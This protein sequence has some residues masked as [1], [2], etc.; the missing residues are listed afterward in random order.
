MN[1][2][3]LAAVAAAVWLAGCAA[4]RPP[5]APLETV[6]AKIAGRQVWS[7][8]IGKVSFPLEVMARGGR[9]YLAADD[10]QVLALDATTGA[11]AWRA[12]V[13]GGI[14]AGVGSDGRFAAV[15]TR[16][17]D[18][19]VLEAGREVWRTAQPGPV[20]TP[21]LVAGERVFVMGSDRIVRAYDALDGRYLWQ[22]KRA[23]DSLTLAQ[24]GV[25]AAYQD[26]LLVGQGAKLV[27]LD[28]TVGT[29][30]WEAA[31]TNPRGTNEIERLADLVG[32][33]NRVGASYCVRAFQS[34]TGC[35]DATNGRVQWS[36]LGGGVEA[37]GGQADAIF[38]ADGSDR[39]SAR[40]R[41]KGDLLWSHERLLNRQLSA[42]AAMGTAVVFGDFEG[43]LHFMDAATG[44]PVL[45]L[46]T[47][48]SRI[49]APLVVEG[50]T[51]VAVTADGGV[52][53]FRPE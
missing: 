31:V 23:G 35:V 48:G 13:A 42:P 24:R 4:D 28:P 29:V 52:F 53:A 40:R 17:N 46:G 39:V 41:D 7:A 51:L 47:D 1:I 44:Q 2:R 11:E 6:Q 43:W 49:A 20:V 32:P 30:R 26:T 22:F 34:A 38:G 10:G 8:R 15:V 45:R 12:Q 5:P 33:I 36:Q 21:P 19:V 50:T 37:V 16:A 27:A 14:A 25:L 18:L 9:L 3:L